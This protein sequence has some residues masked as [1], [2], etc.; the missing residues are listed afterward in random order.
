MY[1]FDEAKGKIETRSVVYDSD[2]SSC[3]YIERAFLRRKLKK[4][5]FEYSLKE[6]PRREAFGYP[7]LYLCYRCGFYWG[8][9]FVHVKL[10]IEALHQP[11]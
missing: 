7:H 2:D 1:N 10:L 9:E 6:L 4:I 3:N 11:C 5:F 8:Y